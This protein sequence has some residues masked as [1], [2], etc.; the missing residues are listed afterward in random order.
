MLCTIYMACISCKSR[1][2]YKNRIV[3]PDIENDASAR[4]S[5][6]FWSKYL[7][8]KKGVLLVLPEKGW[9]ALYVVCEVLVILIRT[10][11]LVKKCTPRLYIEIIYKNINETRISS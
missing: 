8:H 7:L 5:G 9:E 4:S 11:A 10:C 6:S 1:D 2:W 3:R